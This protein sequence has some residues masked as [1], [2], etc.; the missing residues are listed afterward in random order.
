VNKAGWSSKKKGRSGLGLVER[1]QM[2]RI[3]LTTPLAYDTGPWGWRGETAIP[4]VLGGVDRMASLEERN[5]SLERENERLRSELAEQKH[6]LEELGEREELRISERQY[7]ATIDS[8]GDAIHVV[9]RDLRIVL[10]NRP[11]IEWNRELGLQTEMIGRTVF[12]LFPFLPVRVRDEYHRVFSTAETLVNE[13]QVEVGSRTL[14]TEVRKIPVFENDQVVRVVTVIR[15][16]T[17]RK[18]A[19]S[20][21]RE[22]EE[23][24]RTLAEAAHDTIFVVDRED[25]I[26]YVNEYGAKSL[27]RRPEDIIGAS[28]AALFSGEVGE[29][30]YRNLRRV[31]E[32]GKP[33]YE[34]SAIPFPGQELWLGTRLVPIRGQDGSDHSG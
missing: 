18:Q 3:A 14:T 8:M 19:E 16:I 28:R 10:V 34:E 6:A 24:Y 26:S 33:V 22:S 32:N 5:A 30:Q 25:R 7:R 23:R 27:G 15:N 2:N 12:E 20:A 4:L 31:F 13:E 17:V 21:L 9:D 1:R 11:F 29:R